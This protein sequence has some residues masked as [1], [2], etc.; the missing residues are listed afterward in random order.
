MLEC[1]GRGAPWSLPSFYPTVGVLVR[2]S[3]FLLF[4]ISLAPAA[5]LAQVP[6]PD[7]NRPLPPAVPPGDSATEPLSI[8]LGTRIETKLERNQNERCTAGQSLVAF[9]NCRGG[10]QPIF[11]VEFNILSTGTLAERFNVNLDFDSEREFD[12][13]NNISLYYKGRGNELLQ[14]LEVGNVSFTPPPSR[15]IT[16]GIPSGNYGVQAIGRLGGARISLVA[17]QQKGNVKHAEAFTLGD[18]TLQTSENR[19]EDFRYE[20]R[21]FFFTIDPSQLEG[22]PNIDIL[23]TERMSRLASALPDSIRPTRLSLYRLLIGGQPQNPNGPRFIPRGAR[24][25]N[26][27]PVYDYLR[28]G[29][30][31]YADPSRLWIALLRPLGRN[32]R[33]VVA[34]NVEMPNGQTVNPSTGGHPDLEFKT[35]PQFANLLWDSE[36]TPGDPVFNR[37]IRSAYRIGGDELDRSSLDVKIVTGSSGDQEKPLAGTAETY[38]QLFGLAQSSNSSTLDT[39]N[40]LWPRPT[41]PNFNIG[42]TGS[43]K[44]I[45]DYFIVFPS[46]EPFSRRGLATAGNPSN[47]TLYTTP[48]E[49]IT[50]PR[51]P[52]PVYHLDTR[53]ASEGVGGSGTFALQSIQLRRNS[54][55]VEIDGV[56]LIR[57]QD[58]TVDYDLGRITLNRPDTLYLRPRQLSIWYEEQP[59]FAEKPTNIFALSTE[60]PMENGELAFTAIGQRQSSVFT[61]PT[62]GNEAASS[63][64]AGMSARFAWDATAALTSALQRVMSTTAPSRIAFQGELA[65]SRPDANS[66][67]RAFLESFEGEGGITVPLA[68]PR[69]YFSSRP[70]A[71]PSLPDAL[72]DLARASTLV[73]QNTGAGTNGELIAF[74][75]RDIDPLTRL[76]GGAFNSAEPILWLSLLPL[77]VGGTRDASGAHM[78][79][80]AGAPS[81]RRWRSLRTV[82]SPSGVDLTRVEHLEFWALVDTA[83]ATRRANPTLVVDIGD[84]S[85]NSIAFAPDTMIVDRSGTVPTVTGLRGKQ[86]DGVDVLDSER[87]SFT[88]AFDAAVNDLGLPGDRAT[89]I[90]VRDAISGVTTDST[91]VPVC[92]ADRTARRLGDPRINCTVRNDRLDE[93]DIDLDNV[94]NF[95]RDGERI[96]RFPVDLADADNFG[97]VGECLGATDP[98]NRSGIRL[99]WVKVR[100]PLT[101]PEANAIQAPLL[102]RM[103]TLRLTIVSSGDTP[104]DATID[105]PIAGLR[106]TGAPWVKRSDAP[107]AGVAGDPGTTGGGA[108]G[109]YVIATLIG[110]Q[111]STGTIPYSPPPGVIEQADN[112]NTGFTPGQIQINERSMRLLAGGLDV[113]DR[114]EAYYR[115]PEGR[116][117]FMGYEQLRVWARG[118]GE[119]WGPAGELEFFIKIG[120]D[121]DN[122]YLYRTPI[123]AG[124]TQNAWEPEIRVDFARFFAL[125]AEIQNALLRGTETISSCTAAD[126][127]IILAS[128]VPPTAT[129]MRYAACDG[130]YM[131][132][133]VAPNVNPPDLAAVQEMAVGMIR[134]GQGAMPVPSLLSD[135]LE[136]WV[137]DIRLTGVVNEPGYAGHVGLDVQAADFWDM[138]ANLSRRDRDYRQLGEQPT[139]DT[140]DAL[141][142]ISTFQ[143]GKFLPGLGLSAPLTINH[144]SAGSNPYFMSNSDVLAEGVPGLR[145]P[146]SSATSYA[147]TLRRSQP[148]DSTSRYAPLFNNLSLSSTYA[149]TDARSEYQEGQS[150]NFTLGVD[151][152]IAADPRAVRLPGWL[153]R[154]VAILPDWL[155]RTRPLAAFRNGEYRYL[156]SQFRV[157]SALARAT[158]RRTSYATP[159]ASAGDVGRR[160][161]GLNFVWRN[162]AAIEIRPANALTLRWN[163]SSL[164]DLRDYGDTSAASRARER[165]LGQDIGMEREREMRASVSFAPLL[166]PWIRPT[167]TFGSDFT[168]TQDP[169]A[170]SLVVTGPTTNDVL[171][172]RMSGSQVFGAGATIDIATGLRTWLGRIPG[173]DPLAGIFAPAEIMY[174]RSLLSSF[175]RAGD[176]APLSYQFGL[177]TI[178]DFRSHDDELATS[179]ALT[180]AL[181]LGNTLTLPFGLSFQNRFQRTDTRNWTR[182]L[183]NAQSVIDGSQ[184]TFPDANLLWNWRPPA[185]IAPFISNVGAR[186]GYRRTT[187]STLAPA[188]TAESD[189]DRTWDRALSY[190]LNLSVAWEV[191][192]GF[193][194]AASYNVTLTESERPGS[195]ANGR[196]HE[197]GG[198]VSKTFAPRRAWRL[199]GDLRTR[200]GFQRSQN[201]ARV[202][203]T[204]STPGTTGTA[205]SRL[206][207]NGRY[208]FNI[209]ADTD[210]SE[211]A[212]FSLTGARTVTFD[213]NFN[214]R[215]TQTVISAVLHL[216]FFGGSG[217]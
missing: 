210:V 27:G 45:R 17:A 8:N 141:D 216:Q 87:D 129:S 53:Y 22:Y 85:E 112:R 181:T 107:I 169:N 79:T 120:R 207:D 59:L 98:R 33:L 6:V 156:P 88:G 211:T 182:R 111:D 133:S 20:A 123:N 148:L 206:T 192:G 214:R 103:K 78:W 118:R 130:G 56:Q 213:E 166:S 101:A 146:K 74:T 178:G 145:T 125:K 12:A 30:D 176:I 23:D 42:A 41:D 48:D 131:V 168:M 51:R 82:L 126:S 217:R 177:G 50:S 212:S 18:R 24:N 96:L 77:S 137:D 67:N 70:I 189:I 86:L 140:Q 13:S 83:V 32:E 61:R 57:D 153:D 198:E 109:G 19:I 135:T 142:V 26:R 90:R 76:I 94:L 191:L 52:Q 179:A 44:L 75:I 132:Y 196:V 180:N 97:R 202:R 185:S 40:R 150:S 155:L 149:S 136:L 38:L 204:A 208:T 35:D 172:R 154:A 187:R 1:A 170:R 100:V 163:L 25:A 5:A 16:S 183:Q 91:K 92:R 69:W 29:V 105:L 39:E 152:N 175:D 46:L 84:I 110:T 193:T 160:V 128:A 197:Y 173:V 209:G 151:Y 43:Q 66:E 37:E 11:G 174:T 127:A 200:I 65:M 108:T 122:F 143:L 62:L 121:A 144:R 119:G 205:S 158:D 194:T 106:L 162:G 71:S 113:N 95:P 80:I 190:P 164:R 165:F 188:F 184:R 139:F 116:K 72:T 28:E 81:G 186:A 4:A 2:F 54:E 195:I 171:P 64:I 89:T 10:F 99:C 104:D 60:F 102:R 161:D 215:F 157:T 36:V 21:R 93:E 117:S 201:E 49:D 68:D 47:D 15:F 31:Y 115:F 147:L 55:R 3:T 199:P 58:Y 73:W 159:A 63:L 167:L 9:T 138:R 134:V 14:R 114:A 7:P 203:S 34:Y 124:N